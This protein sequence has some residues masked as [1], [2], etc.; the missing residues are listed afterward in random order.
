MSVCF[1]VNAVFGGWEGIYNY[2]VDR[3]QSLS[4]DAG[5][6]DKLSSAEVETIAMGRLTK[7][8][9]IGMRCRQVLWIIG[10]TTGTIAAM[11]IY[12]ALFHFSNLSVTLPI[13]IAIFLVAYTSP[14]FMAA[15]LVVGFIFNHKVK[16]QIDKLQERAE[17]VERSN[18]SNAVSLAAKIDQSV[19]IWGRLETVKKSYRK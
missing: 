14:G 15:M 10:R 5:R 8:I 9:K 1:G 2:I 13:S 19:E 12:I 4:D 18:R 6:L 7:T 3:Q 16:A 11:A 17:E